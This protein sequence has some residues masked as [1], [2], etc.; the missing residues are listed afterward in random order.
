M[1][2]DRHEPICQLIDKSLTGAATLDEERSLQDH[3]STCAACRQYLETSQR[4]ILSLSGFA[5]EVNPSLQE[6]V[7]EALVAQRGDDNPIP[8]WWGR[9]AALVLTVV[10]SFATWRIAS[11]AAAAFHL[12]P[13]QIQLGL[14]AFWIAPSICFCLLLLLLP[15][16]ADG[17]MNKKGSSL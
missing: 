13:A 5:F 17:W 16:S 10:G 2:V 15:F 14:A 6:K 11:L 8:V 12:Q 9:V 4:A 1:Q 3:L 7:M